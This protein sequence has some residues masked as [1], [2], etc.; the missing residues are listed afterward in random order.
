MK[1]FLIAGEASGD[2]LGAALMRGLRAL[3]PDVEFHGIGGPDMQAAGM[4]SLFPMDELSV[5]GLTEVL[6][7]LRGLLRRRDEAAEAVLALGP[8]A[9][10]T[11]DSPDFCLRVAKRVKATRPDLPVIHYV[12]PS[13]WAWREG[14]AAKMARH[15]DH[16]LALLPMEPPLMQAAGVSC[17]FVGHPVAAEPQPDRADV[18]AFRLGLP[19]EGPVLT[20]LPGSRRSEV[21]KL[22]PVFGDVTGR[23]G[24]V[25]VVVPAAP[26]VVDMV[27]AQVAKWPVPVTV[28]DPRG[29]DPEAA[30]ARKRVAFAASDAALAASGT[31]ALELAAA[32][33]P[34]VIAYK[35]SWLTFAIM[36]RMIKTPHVS[37]VNILTKSSVVPELLQQE[38]T[39]DRIAQA[40]RPILGG[41]SDQATACD[42]VMEMLGRGGEAPGLRAARSVLSALTR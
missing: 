5:M 1:L 28:L 34:M 39:P 7:R 26:G 14:R 31:V 18:E 23:V 2:R 9:L 41:E 35:M 15:V 29:M 33:T 30:A 32:R 19:G 24:P 13:V 36:S 37:L 22:A 10:I 42:K 27:E 12:A 20:V 21:E 11:I 17:D 3:V 38:C 25:R 6:P 16:V 4:T 40:L 8:D